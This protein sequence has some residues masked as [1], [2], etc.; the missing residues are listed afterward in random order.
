M[1][2]RKRERRQELSHPEKLQLGTVLPEEQRQS[3]RRADETVPEYPQND[4][5]AAVETPAIASRRHAS[6]VLTIW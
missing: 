4:R 5:D 6:C 2:K 3:E 1:T